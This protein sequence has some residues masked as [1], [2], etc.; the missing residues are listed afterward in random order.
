[1][2]MPERTPRTSFSACHIATFLDL[3]KTEQCPL[4]VHRVENDAEDMV[5]ERISRHNVQRLMLPSF[6]ETATNDC[7]LPQYNVAHPNDLPEELTTQRWRLMCHYLRDIANLAPT[8]RLAVSR[9]LLGL[10]FHEVLRKLI[11]SPIPDEIARDENVANLAL[12]RA[13]AGSALSLDSAS[14]LDL[15]EYELIAERAPNGSLP[16]LWAGLNL[17]VAAAKEL[18]RVDLTARW[19]GEVH[20]MVTR[21]R[22]INEFDRAL[23]FSRVHRGT[24]FH[25]FLQG[26][27]NET[28]TEMDQAEHYA[29]LAVNVAATP[30]E[31]LLARENL[32]TALESRS[33]E[34]LAFRDLDLA[35]SRMRE[36]VDLDRLDP[37]NFL[38]LGDILA[39]RGKI[40]EALNTYRWAVRLGPPATA[41][42]CF[43]CGQCLER[44]GREAEAAD[45]YL[46]VLAC[47]PL[48]IS[49][50]ERLVDVAK[51][52]G[53][54]VI[55][56]WSQRHVQ[57]LLL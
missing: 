35:E 44:L 31:Q 36:M 48:G 15:R 50:A 53:W 46:Q 18:R 10:G 30:K 29:R 39:R 27:Q 8:S 7:G 41:T 17:V 14:G 22:P 1:M 25:P 16:K 33:K 54:A 4:Y 38:E 12:V 51:K 52:L 23:V 56:E 57:Q 19:S 13:H 45:C 26:K 55:A 3:S 40:E 42:A 9:I 24:A 32:M 37:K 34:A 2:N 28:I 6:R 49:A 11:P 5:S 43:M 20:K 47:D 21:L